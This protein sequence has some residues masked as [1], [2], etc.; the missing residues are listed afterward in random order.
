MSRSL[1]TQLSPPLATK[2]AAS[3]M[4]ACAVERLGEGTTFDMDAWEVVPAE[5]KAWRD[6]ERNLTQ[7]SAVLD[8]VPAANQHGS[9]WDELCEQS[10]HLSNLAM[11]AEIAARRAFRR[12]AA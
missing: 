3:C 5:W 10:E 7:L 2:A 12:V 6:A 1:N 8:S 4:T 11:D 9:V